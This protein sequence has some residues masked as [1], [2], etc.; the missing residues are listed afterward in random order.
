MVNHPS[1]QV[2]MPEFTLGDS[3]TPTRFQERRELL[4]T[5]E[6]NSAPLHEQ[7][8]VR[9]MDGNY[10]RAIDLLTS[11]KVRAAFDIRQEKDE[12]RTRYG[13]NLFGQSCLLA[14]RLVEAGSRFIQVNWYGEPAW[15]GWDTHGADL[16]GL[17][18]MES[19]LCP[20]LDQGLSALL[21]DLQQRGMLDSTLVVVT[22]EFGRT[23]K[24]NT[25]GGRDHWPQCFSIL[26]A[27]AG[28]PGGAVI[29]AS[30]N[31]GAYP[32][33]RPVA[34]P[35][36]AATIY[37]LL[38]INTNLDVRIRPFIGDAAPMPELV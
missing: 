14:R 26:L 30:D 18:R 1:K 35:E 33:V 5:V 4:K 34:V 23:P 12:I 37:R 36:F 17:L 16:P 7:V 21:V 6:R 25:Y 27:G 13:G 11:D 31:H 32:A 22:G 38:G 3:V 19:P 28:V 9:E 15:H 24:I 8:A 29:G 20:R 10:R 2:Q